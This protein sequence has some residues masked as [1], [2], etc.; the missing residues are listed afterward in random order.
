MQ[1]P[2]GSLTRCGKT[3][4]IL[5]KDRPGQLGNR[6][7]QALLR[8]AVNIVAEGIADAED[9][10]IAVKTGLGIRMPVYGPFE[11]ANV[12]GLDAVLNIMNYV[13]QDLY[14]EPRA[15]ELFQRLV[16]AG[17][18][19]V[20]TGKGFYDWSKKDVDSVLRL[21]DRFVLEWVRK[22]GSSSGGH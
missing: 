15:P 19:G 22:R 10:D 4:V 12:V 7:Q 8:E 17:N 20:K 16:A 6:L 11:H 1:K 5:K 13:S 3:V 21:R 18:L 2:C 9:V 14:N